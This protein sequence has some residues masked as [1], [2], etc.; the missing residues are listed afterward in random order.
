M[1]MLKCNLV[2]TDEIQ[3]WGLFGGK[4]YPMNGAKE[5]H[6]QGHCIQCYYASNFL[7]ISEIFFQ[8]YIKYNVCIL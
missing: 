5:K 2:S 1:G 7:K 6:M 8:Y 4:W 3:I